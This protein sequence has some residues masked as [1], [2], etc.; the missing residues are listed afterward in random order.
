MEEAVDAGT[1]NQRIEHR[2]ASDR[3]ADAGVCSEAATKP[4]PAFGSTRWPGT[5]H[6]RQPARSDASKVGVRKDPGPTGPSHQL[7]GQIHLV[8]RM[9]T[10]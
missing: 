6:D 7:S 2:I 8:P 1:A 4:A 5:T 9:D 10:N 3:H